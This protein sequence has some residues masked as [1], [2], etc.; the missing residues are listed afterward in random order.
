MSH[1]EMA[2]CHILLHGVTQAEQSNQVGHCGP[3]HA[4][5]LGNVVVT[6]AKPLVERLERLSFLDRVEVFALQVFDDAH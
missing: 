3:V 5:F 1:G 2:V 6:Q 4:D